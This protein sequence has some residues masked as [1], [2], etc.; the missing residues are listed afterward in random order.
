[1]D[2]NEYE[3]IRKKILKI[4]ALADRGVDGEAIMARRMLEQWLEKYN[5]SLADILDE[6]CRTELYE[7][8]GVTNGCY[9]TLLTHCYAKVMN[10]SSMSY[11]K[12]GRRIFLDLTAYQYAELSAMF[13]WYRTRL[14]REIEKLKKDAAVAFVTKHHLFSEAGGDTE[15]KPLSK[16]EMNRLVRILGMMDSMDDDTYVKRLNR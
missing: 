11:R 2:K 1:M 6:E 13:D 16:A 9:L 12:Y 3:S 14:K 15:P 8:K 7:I 5:L 4:K 10:R